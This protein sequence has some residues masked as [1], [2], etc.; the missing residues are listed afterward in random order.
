MR[1]VVGRW[2]KHTIDSIGTWVGT[3]TFPL[4]VPCDNVMALVHADRFEKAAKV[5]VTEVR[6]YDRY[7]Q[8]KFRM[9]RF[10]RWKKA[11]MRSIH[12]GSRR[13]TH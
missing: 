9:V 2:T 7:V 3:F 13:I 6:N 10:P 12:K 11:K 1:S 8:I 4:T 5:V